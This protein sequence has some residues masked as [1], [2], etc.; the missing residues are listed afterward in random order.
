MAGIT[1]ETANLR[2]ATATTSE[3]IIN[4]LKDINI[5]SFLVPIVP[6]GNGYN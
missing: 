4:I 1:L 2:L 5:D 3:D 6:D